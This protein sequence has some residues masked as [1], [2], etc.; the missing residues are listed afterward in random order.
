MTANRER[1]HYPSSGEEPIPGGGHSS[2]AVTVP[3]CCLALKTLCPALLPSHQ[4]SAKG[5][6]PWKS[7]MWL[8][9]G[10]G[11]HFILWIWRPLEQCSV[12]LDQGMGTRTPSCT[13]VFC[14]VF[15]GLHL[16]VHRVHLWCTR[17]HTGW[18]RLSPGRKCG[19]PM[20]SRCAASQASRHTF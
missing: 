10:A 12:W 19:K 14:F 2:G 17:D 16:E 11:D 8:D 13:L 15:L 1:H 18:H 20:P 3:S 7:S 4:I 5:A 9:P 6:G